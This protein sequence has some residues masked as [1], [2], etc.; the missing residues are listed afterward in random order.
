MKSELYWLMR[1]DEEPN[2]IS[3][4][5]QQTTQITES[6]KT[7]KKYITGCENETVVRPNGNKPRRMM[8]IEH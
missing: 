5:I 8:E 4:K 1:L 6:G 3:C 2:F 7:R